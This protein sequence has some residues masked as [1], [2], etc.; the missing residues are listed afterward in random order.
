MQKKEITIV[1]VLGVGRSGTSLLHSIISSHKDVT[2]IKETQL[3]RNILT[4]RINFQNSPEEILSEI[5]NTSNI[6]RLKIPKSVLLN[7]ISKSISGQDFYLNLLGTQLKERG[8]I[9]FC[10]KDPKLITCLKEIKESKLPVKVIHIYRDPR[11]VISSRMKVE[12]TKFKNVLLHSL[13]CNAQLGM[14]KSY[15][16]ELVIKDVSYEK[17]LSN[18]REEL[19]AICTFLKLGYTNDMLNFTETSRE[20]TSK[21]ETWKKNTQKSLQVS[22]TNK[23]LKQLKESQIKSVETFYPEAFDYYGYDRIYRSNPLSLA[24][25]RLLANLSSTLY[26]IMS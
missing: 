16:K 6:S 11:A 21:E 12:W 25:G 13:V 4:K 24:F 15:R 23:F 26:R 20:L 18:P 19:K 8:N 17:L 22:N 14:L 7:L 1:L 10:D 2:G 5:I 9:V 3:L